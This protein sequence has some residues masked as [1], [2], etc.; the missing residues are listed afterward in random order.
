MAFEKYYDETKPVSGPACIHFRSK[1]MCVTGDLFDD[2]RA[3]EA[4][5]QNCWCN[6][7]QHVIGP[8]SQDVDRPNCSPGRDCYR[9][10]H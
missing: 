1:S 6:I 5:N 2:S 3:D 8:D 7:T 10:S 9:D 4:G